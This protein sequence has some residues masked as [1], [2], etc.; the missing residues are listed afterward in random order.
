MKSPPSPNGTGRPR[1]DHAGNDAAW[2]ISAGT[3]QC[4]HEADTNM[5]RDEWRYAAPN[6]IQL[7]CP[8]AENKYSLD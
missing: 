1:T 3:R 8:A 4:A 5:A 2:N 7:D 6:G